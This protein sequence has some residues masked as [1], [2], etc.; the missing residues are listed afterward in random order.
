MELEF[1]GNTEILVNNG[2]NVEEFY[3]D[4]SPPHGEFQNGAVVQWTSVLDF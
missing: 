2:F 1:R 4:L 3:V